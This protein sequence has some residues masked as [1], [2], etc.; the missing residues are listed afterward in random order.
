MK[1][2]DGMLLPAQLSIDERKQTWDVMT[3]PF[4]FLHTQTAGGFFAA[5]KPSGQ[6]QSR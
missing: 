1:T 6:E 2:L 4:L 3:S 5:C